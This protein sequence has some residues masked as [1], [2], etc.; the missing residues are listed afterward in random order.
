[1][2]LKL[3]PNDPDCSCEECTCDQ[4]QFGVKRE[5]DC[6]VCDCDKC[7]PSECFCHDNA[8]SLKGLCECET[9]CS[10]ECQECDCRNGDKEY[11]S[12]TS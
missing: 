10:C 5:C 12:I 3:W 6:M 9:D 1:M 8:Q 2:Q 7:H 4:A 11:L